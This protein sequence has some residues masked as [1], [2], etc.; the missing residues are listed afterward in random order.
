MSTVSILEQLFNHALHEVGAGGC[1]QV[2]GPRVGGARR[3]LPI[4][5]SQR[6]HDR[7]AESK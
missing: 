1:R 3:L 5:K 4:G 7:A 2:T 6:K